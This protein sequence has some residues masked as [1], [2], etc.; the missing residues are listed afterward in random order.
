[1]DSSLGEKH[2]LLRIAH[3]NDNRIVL[4]LTD[5]E[6]D[7]SKYHEEHLYGWVYNE[8]SDSIIEQKWDTDNLKRVSEVN[9]EYVLHNI[10]FPYNLREWAKH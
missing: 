10:L 8:A 6:L 4:L 3:T 5:S 1:M 2:E 9:K 7:S